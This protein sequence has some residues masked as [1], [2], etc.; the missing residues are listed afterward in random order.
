M[1]NS[2]RACAS[3]VSACSKSINRA[4]RNARSFE[5]LAA[6]GLNNVDGPLQ[7]AHALLQGLAQTLDEQAEVDAVSA[8][9]LDATAR[10]RVEKSLFGAAHGFYYIATFLCLCSL[11]QHAS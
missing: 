10:R 1:T 6:R 7:V 4:A 8:R 2:T 11:F 9:R 5:R 3:A